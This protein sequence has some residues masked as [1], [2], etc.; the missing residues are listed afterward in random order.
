MSSIITKI[1]IQKKNKDRVNIYMNDEFAFACDAA[2]VY[3]HNIT[4]GATIEKEGLQDIIDEDNYIKGKNCA[5]HFLERSF[6]SA[7]QVVDKLTIKE[8]DIKTIDRVME[9][10]KQ[11]DF[12]DD[13]RFV[14]L[15]IKEKIKSTGKNKIKFTLLK[16]SLPKE[17]IKEALNKITSEEQLQVALLLG[18]RRMA[19]LA[20]SEKNALKLYKKTWDYLVRNGYDFGIVNE[21]LDKITENDNNEQPSEKEHS[22]DNYEEDYKKI[23]ELASKRYNILIK[24]EPSKIKLYKKLGDYLLRRG[25]KWDEIKKVLGDLINGVEDL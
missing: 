19:T 13:K 2:L 3:I 8:F 7:K 1:E 16:K 20:K 23:Q 18:E 21:V 17:L 11:Y 24:S 15:F 12:V 14:D 22:E 5:L 9:F 25:Y 6:K 10:L 4:K